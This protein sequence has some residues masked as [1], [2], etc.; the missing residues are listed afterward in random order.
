MTD[1]RA[2]K[3]L[4]FLSLKLRRVRT[5]YERARLRGDAERVDQY[6]LQLSAIS[7]ERDRLVRRLTSE[8]MLS[9]R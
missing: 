1:V 9:A 2:Q 4:D 3:D 7:A 5:D 6:R 8:A